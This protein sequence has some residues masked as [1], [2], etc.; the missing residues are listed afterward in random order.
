MYAL[1]TQFQRNID[2]FQQNGGIS[3]KTAENVQKIGAAFVSADAVSGRQTKF[4]SQIFK[5]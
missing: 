1:L 5:S 4:S 2:F 3:K